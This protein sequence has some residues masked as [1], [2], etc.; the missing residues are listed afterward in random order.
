MPNPIVLA[1]A[2]DAA[3]N[4]VKPVRESITLIAGHG[5]EGD[6]HAGKTVQHRYDKRRNPEAPNL[7]QVHLM[8][9]ELFDKVSEF[10]IDVSPGQM[11]EN[12]TTRGIDILNLP[13]GTHLKIGEAVIEITGLRN[14]CKYL[15]QIAPG[16]LK[17]CLAKHE[18]GTN[19]P[20]SGVMGVIIT[21]GAVKPGD[22]I[23][24]IAPAEPH[25]RLRPV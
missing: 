12:I 4:I 7:R 9:A 6:A 22:I 13:R 1:V 11:G 10:S 23:H 18:D 24:I 8:H 19:F 14:P 2:S 25:E 16:L 5:V 21:G 15:N 17:A 3:H 20:Q